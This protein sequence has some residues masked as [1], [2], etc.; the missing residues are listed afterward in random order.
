[1]FPSRTSLYR[2][3]EALNLNRHNN[4]Q[5]ALD[6]IIE[7]A[8]T[9]TVTG[10][11]VL[12]AIELSLRIAG[13]NVAPLMRYEVTYKHEGTPIPKQRGPKPR[14]SS[15]ENVTAAAEPSLKPSASSLQ[16]N[17]YSNRYT[18]ILN[19]EQL[20]ENKGEP[21]K[22]IG[23]QGGYPKNQQSAVREPL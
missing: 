2:H 21:N 17:R 20:A 5:S 7:S 3:A 6:H 19:S 12:R 18:Q 11:D 16:D 22:V 14:S 4:L 10:S 15:V 8:A 13:V 9:V 23:T 1:K